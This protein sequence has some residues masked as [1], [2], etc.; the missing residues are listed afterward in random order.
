VAD[1]AGQG[2]TAARWSRMKLLFD[3]SGRGI[4]SPTGLGNHGESLARSRDEE[5]QRV[6]ERYFY[7]AAGDGV[8]DV[9]KRTWE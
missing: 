3:K 7:G 5:L 9:E 8:R 1:I 4:T 6:A 2:E